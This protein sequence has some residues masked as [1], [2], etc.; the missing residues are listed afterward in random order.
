MQTPLWTVELSETAL[1]DFDEIIHHTLN[2]FGQMQADR[3]RDLI[4][5]SLQELSETGPKHP[6]ASDRSELRPA[7]KSLPIRRR[8]VNARHVL[9]FTEG[10]GHPDK[11][12]LIVRILHDAMD[13]IDHLKT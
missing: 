10:N 8:G 13:V 5:Q 3:S 7:M 11:S 2:D 1:S 4:A 12:I 6:L 9:F